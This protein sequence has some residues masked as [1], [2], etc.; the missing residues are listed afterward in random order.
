MNYLIFLILIFLVSFDINAD[1]KINVGITTLI[2]KDETRMAWDGKSY[3]P[4]ASHIFYPTLDKHLHP[5][6]LGAPGEELFQAGIAAWNVKPTDKTELPLIIMSHGTGGSALQMLWIAEKLV[7]NGYIVIGVNHHGN[8]AIEP[9]K[10][11]EGYMLWWERTQDLSVVLKKISVDSEWSSYIDK[12]KIGVVGFSLGGYTAISALGGI[13]DKSLFSKFCQSSE[14]DFTCD[15]QQEFST[16]V[17]EF[18][19]VKHTKR[20][21]ESMLRQHQSYKIDQIKAAFVLA[22]A[23]VQSFTKESLQSIDVPVSVVV[24]SKDQIAPAKTNAKRITSLVNGASY[25]E[26]A[27]GGHYIFLSNCTVLGR[28]YLKNLCS[29]DKNIVRKK[30]HETVS[31]NILDFFNRVFLTKSNI[32]NSNR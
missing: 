1:D 5:V 23:V 21:K 31:K 10:Y 13:T 29:D 14:K 15:A 25:T 3:R 7:K 2:F 12:N 18:I 20:V 11:A 9:K 8:T 28:K 27:N 22:P 30:V 32:D 24:G 4:I 6:M 17:D 16:I 19:K 26:I